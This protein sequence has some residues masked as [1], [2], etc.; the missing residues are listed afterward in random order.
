DLLAA[1][2]GT[3]IVEDEVEVFLGQLRGA[4]RGAVEAQQTLRGEDDERPRLADQRLAAQQVEVLRGRGR[5]GDAD[6]AL[7]AEGEEALDAGARVLRPRALVSVGQ[8]QRQPARL[9]PLRL[10]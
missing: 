6:V 10:A 7:G 9:P 2:G 4:R 3:L 1:L 8:Q 5:V